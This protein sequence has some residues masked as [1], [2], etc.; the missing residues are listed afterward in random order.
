M[1]WLAYSQ[2]SKA[3]FKNSN[4]HS[5]AEKRSF[6]S[7]IF[8][9]FLEL[10][11][12]SHLQAYGKKTQTTFVISTVTKV[13]THIDPENGKAQLVIGLS[14][15]LSVTIALRKGEETKCKY[16][17]RMSKSF[18]MLLQS[19]LRN[20]SLCP[21]VISQ[22]PVEMHKE[23]KPRQIGWINKITTLEE[24]EE[25]KWSVSNCGK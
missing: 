15:V 6:S 16:L 23:G 19:Y 11:T 24:P 8:Q 9:W 13:W 20:A 10:Q 12:S 2:I 1:Q 21:T 18:K 17:L 5:C 14:Q 22:V 4:S 3:E 25:K 7:W